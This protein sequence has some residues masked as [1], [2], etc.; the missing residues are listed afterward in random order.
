MSL[1]HP[2]PTP[3]AVLLVDSGATHTRA[4]LA[5][6][7]GQIYGWDEAG[8]GNAFAVGM[9]VGTLNLRLAVR[10]ALRSSGLSSGVIRRAVA[11]IAGVGSLG[12]DAAPF[13]STLQI[14]LPGSRVSIFGDTRTAFEGALGGEPGV[15]IVSGTGSVVFGCDPQGETV[16]IGGWGAWIGDEGSS[17]WISR[18]ALRRAAHAVD[19]MGAST[20]LVQA[21]QQHFRV[22]SF[23]EMV[24]LI[25]R[26][27]SPA[28][29]GSLAPLV[30]KVAQKGDYV[31]Q[32][33]FRQSGEMLAIQAAS[34]LRRLQLKQPVVS[35]QGAVFRAGNLLL[36]PMRRSLRRL[37]PRA[38][39]I[40]PRLPPLGGAWL[41]AL[42]LE[43]IS[44][45]ACSIRNFRRNC[46]EWISGGLG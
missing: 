15:V 45:S 8:P 26:A 22:Q 17:Q 31:A 34:A 20:E 6:D 33:I 28:S 44:P 46:Q 27:P 18:E 9:K 29:L 19:G 7:Q 3:T 32:Q 38:R 25:Y 1:K 10:G 41:M 21:F 23:L 40:A 14:L 39:L 37:V 42:W 16:K 4:C 36:T 35:Y 30:V 13:S 5:D 24:K 11:G 2:L 12:K 43:G